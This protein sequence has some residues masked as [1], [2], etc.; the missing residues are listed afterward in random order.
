[1]QQ[2]PSLTGRQTPWTAEAARDRLS[3][4]A[5]LAALFHGILILGIT[6]SASSLD[7][8]NLTSS[9]EVVLVTS[10]YEDRAPPDTA[11]LLAQQNLAGVGNAAPE[12][13]VRTAP[14]L[15]QVADVL[16]PVREGSDSPARPGERSHVRN[17]EPVLLARDSATVAPDEGLPDR[18]TEAQ[19]SMLPSTSNAI[20]IVGRFDTVTAIPDARPRELL[21][22]ANTREARIATYLSAWKNKVEQVGTLNFPFAAS[23]MA[24]S[25]YPV[26]EVAIAADGELREVV[27]RA[28]SGR[29]DLDQ[30]A[31]EILRLAAPFQ[32]FPENLRAEYDV[33]RFAYEWRFSDAGGAVRARTAAAR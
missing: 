5:F 17:P 23:T 30:A 33:L 9:M 6:F 15:A 8:E 28:S 20:E 7:P 16:G 3:S 2:T 12:T 19:R 21:I 10:E 29:R 31:Q 22:S 1:M 18:A 25:Q 32:P 14:G 11:V 26:L 24:N 4:T 27:V 13:T